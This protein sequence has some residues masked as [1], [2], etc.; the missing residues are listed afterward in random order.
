[1]LGPWFRDRKLQLGRSRSKVTRC[2]DVRWPRG[3]EVYDTFTSRPQRARSPRRRRSSV[4]L[5]SMRYLTDGTGSPSVLQFARR[6]LL[7]PSRGVALGQLRL[8][9]P[10]RSNATRAVGEGHDDMANDHEKNCPGKNVMD[11]VAPIATAR[12]DPEPL[13]HCPGDEHHET[14]TPTKIAL[15]FG[16]G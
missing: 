16:R 3:P 11:E 15:S 4:W 6:L 8:T 13:Q 5:R 12:K 10:L 7:N 2:C 14:D 1:M 9:Q